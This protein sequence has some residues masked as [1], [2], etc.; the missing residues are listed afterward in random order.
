MILPRRDYFLFY[1]SA[2]FKKRLRVVLRDYVVFVRPHAVKR[3]A[4]VYHQRA[5]TLAQYALGL[6][7]HLLFMLDAK[8]QVGDD[9]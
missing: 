3:A 6:F 1:K 2:E 9:D 7:D 5:A 4:P 8:Q